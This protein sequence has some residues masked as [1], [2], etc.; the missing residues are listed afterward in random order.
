MSAQHVT[1][2]IRA[3]LIKSLVALLLFMTAESG[4]AQTMPHKS[5][6]PPC[7][8]CHDESRW[9]TVKF[10][11]ERTDFPLIG[12]HRQISCPLCHDVRD[13]KTAS[14]ACADCH[15][16]VHQG[17][18][19]HACDRCHTPQGWQVFDAQRAHQQ[20]AFPLLGAHSRLDCKTCHRGEIEGEFFI[21]SSQC[22]SC[23]ASDFNNAQS[24]IHTDLGF[25]RRCE[26]CHSLF[27]WKPA[28]FAKHDSYFPIYSGAHYGEWDNCTTC[29][30]QAGNYK[31]FSCF[32]NCH[33][34]SQS[35][36]NQRH[37]EV[38]GYA[39]DSKRCYSC[40]PR[41]RGGD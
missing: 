11:H 37:H 8:D 18:L 38:R 3:V 30:Y 16:D 36:T 26:E 5:V 21:L 35:E 2:A 23:H 34:H 28:D 24:T 33:K 13:F 1:T 15:L 40:H 31:E 12:H 7:R 41:G 17:R 20:T 22:N 29:H 39:Y 25:S 10:D 9:Q 4:W 32:T 14:S 6:Q 19:G 27:A